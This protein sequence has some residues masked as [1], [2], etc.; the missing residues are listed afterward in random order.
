MTQENGEASG[1][2][3][4]RPRARLISLIGE[5]LISDEAVALVELI[6]NAYDAD[7][8]VVTVKF[9]YVEGSLVEIKVQDDGHGMTTDELLNSW[10][11]PGTA[12]KR[13]EKRSPKGRLFQGAKGIGRFASA[14]LGDS[15]LIETTAQNHQKTTAIIN[16]GKFQ[17]NGFLDEISLDYESSVSENDSVGTAITIFS[18]GEDKKWDENNF[19]RLHTRLAR[20][21]SPFNESSFSSEVH[22]F[23]ISLEIPGRPEFSG[24]IQPP[25]ITQKPI[26]KLSGFLNESGEFESEIIY[27]DR[28]I[29]KN[30]RQLSLDSGEKNPVCGPFSIEIRAWDRDRESLDPFIAEYQYSLTKIRE[31]LDDYCGV[32]LYRDGFRVYPYGEPNNDWLALDVRSRQNPTMRLS[33]NQIIGAIKTSI[34]TNPGLKDRT[35][36]EGLVHNSE[37]E[38]LREWIKVCIQSLEEERYKLRP[39]KK[40]KEASKLFDAFDLSDLKQETVEQLGKDHLVA[41]LTSEKDKELKS[42]IKNLQEHFSRLMLSAGF[43]QLVDIT[44]HEIGAPLGRANRKVDAVLSGLLESESKDYDIDIAELIKSI[45]DIQMY[46]DQISHRRDTLL[47]KTAGRRNKATK[48]DLI[49]EIEGNISLFES[50]IKKQRIEVKFDYPSS[51]IYAHMSRNSVGQVISNLIDNAIYWTTKKQGPGNGGKIIISLEVKE[52]AFSVYVEDDGPGVNGEDYA[53]IFEMNFSRKPNG[54]GLGLY[55]AREVISN[56]GKLY[57]SESRHLNGASFVA[58]FEKGLV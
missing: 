35:T 9:C 28:S 19:K 34:Q 1:T 37:F 42:S 49:E 57:L 25:D 7:A 29:E 48:F 2:A 54:M 43:G 14:R 33:N 47:P 46:L 50:L 5:E 21:T 26:Y 15:L 52:K 8:S 30:K 51:P 45:N 6:K 39:R 20:L 27:H 16:W 32:S 18:I 17:N 53:S 56:Y 55:V 22:D 13:D 11:Q 36:R 10:F 40:V 58:E 31:I 4:M 24:D 3:T 44:V 12:K 41:R 23:S 38:S